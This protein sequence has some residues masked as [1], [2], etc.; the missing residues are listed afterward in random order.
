MDRLGANVN[1]QRPPMGTIALTGRAAGA[2]FVSIV[3]NDRTLDAS[4]PSNATKGVTKL[5]ARMVTI[6]SRVSRCGAVLHLTATGVGITTEAQLPAQPLLARAYIEDDRPSM[7]S[8]PALPANVVI[9]PPYRDTVESMLLSSATFRHQCSRIGRADYLH[10]VIER[11]LAP[12]NNSGAAVT[13]ITRRPSGGLDANVRVGYLGDPVELVAH[14]FEH[15]LEQLDGVDLASMAAR[16]ATGVHATSPSG[17]FE[18]DRAIAVGRKVAHEVYG[19]GR[20]QG[21]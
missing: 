20:K 6:A 1:S 10:V 3:T 14:E 13:R 11:S 19:S 21:N 9:A 4:A 8:F 18:T 16:P 12:G 17:H 5:A 7:P 15:L 2:Y